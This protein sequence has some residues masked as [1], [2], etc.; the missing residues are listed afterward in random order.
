MIE[1]QK[2]IFV[3]TKGNFGGAQ[4]YVFDLASHLST[5][6][7]DV[8]VA[9]GEGTAL[10][11]KLTACGIRVIPLVGLVRDVSLLSDIKAFVELFILFRHE[12]PD[13]VH[14]NSSKAGG[15]GSFAF[16]CFQFLNFLTSKSYKL[17][18]IFTAHGFAFYENRPWLARVT[19]QCVSWFT[20]LLSHR[21]IVLNNRDKEAMRMW[22]WV[23]WKIQK[24]KLGMENGSAFEKQE[25]LLKLKA[26]GMTACPGPLIGTIAELHVNK[27]LPYLIGAL[28]LLPA[29]V[30]L[31]II[32]NGGEKENLEWLARELGVASR[33]FFA[34]FLDGASRYL[35]AFDLFALPSL[36]EGTPYVLLEAGNQGIPVVASDVG[37]IGEVIVNKQTGLLV[38]PKNPARLA[39]SIRFSFA[40]PEETLRY[41][42]ALRLKIKA[43]FSLDRMLKETT[44]LYEDM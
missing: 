42:E 33:I 20:I 27:G 29:D 6:R 3:I 11:E 25:A 44:K 38:P 12:R 37:G 22:P 15:L 34:G 10:K 39:E 16:R 21:T 32:G 13:I 30:S 7:F 24:I 17:K 2:I 26:A 40:H 35:L 9:V 41:G 8:A 1:R 23:G 5:E 28:T 31:C 43:E 14:L 36:K 19:I 18:A 4:R